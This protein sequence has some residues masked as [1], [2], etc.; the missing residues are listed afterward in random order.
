M[1][2]YL[3]KLIKTQVLNGVFWISVPEADVFV[4]CGCPEDVVKHLM[5]RGLIQN[6]NRNGVEFENGP[7]MILLSDVSIQNGTFCNLGEFPVLQMLYRQ[8]MII[9][10]HPNNKGQKPLIMGS[11]N[12]IKAQL[13]YIYRGNYGLTTK[14]EIMDAGESSDSADEQM[15]MKLSFAF[16]KILDSNE[17]L[18]SLEITNEHVEI[19]NDVYIKRKAL[20]VF[21]FTYGDEVVEV[22]INLGPL[23]TYSSTYPLGFPNLLREYFSVVHTGQ[24]DGWDVNRPS[25]SSIIFF[26]GK[27]YLIDAGPNICYSLMALGIGINEIEGVFHTHCHDDHFAGLTTLIRADHKIKYYSTPLVRASVFKKLG[28]LLQAD[29]GMLESFFEIH[30]LEVDKWNYIEGLEIKPCF[31]P[32]PVETTLLLFRTFWDGRFITYSHLADIASFKVL[33]NMTQGEN[34]TIGITQERVDQVKS[35]YLTPAVLKKIDIG[36]GMIHG[37]A[38]DFKNDTSDKIV[39]AHQA[40]RLSNRQK[41]IGSSAPFGTTDVLIADLSDNSRRF[42]FEFLK[43][44]FPTMER[45]LLRSLLNCPIKEIMPGTII[46]KKGAVNEHIH[47]ILSGNIEQFD[48]DNGHYNMISAGGLIGEHSGLHNSKSQATCRTINYVQILEIPASLYLEF[49]RKSHL[50]DYIDSLH[51]KKLFLNSTWIFGEG[52]SPPIQN[53][54]AESMEL[55]TFEASP[56]EIP[57][58][59]EDAIY[60]IFDGQVERKLVGDHFDIVKNTEFFGEGKAFLDVESI[61]TYH[62]NKGATAYMISYDVLFEIP[63]VMWK[64]FETIEKRKR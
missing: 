34:D 49:V 4:V 52:L 41:E 55:V 44:Y 27:I 62:S 22:D 2:R 32:H 14:Q 12:Q 59:V 64:F 46:L 23:E 48:T 13:D 25:M 18:D 24:G 1:A 57:S 15:A 39:L 5:Q 6:V 47:L 58:L 10:G 42:G 28:A 3:N 61:Y 50:L 30:N 36:G 35:I 63:I 16:G 45:Y 17:L 20:N 29:R 60:V 11:K 9:P 54:I 43:N 53:K 7:N 51:E 33:D 26:Q 56:N 38:E 8:G 19:K 31:S 40:K 37:N 21:E